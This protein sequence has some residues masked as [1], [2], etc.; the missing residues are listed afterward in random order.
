MFFISCISF[1]YA[2]NQKSE[3]QSAI[4]SE[5]KFRDTVYG[6]AID[7]LNNDLGLITPVDEPIY[8]LKHFTYTGTNEIWITK[9]WTS[10]PHYIC[11]YPKEKLIPNKIYSLKICLSHKSRSGMVN[12]QLGFYLS[13][14]HMIQLHLKGHY[15]SKN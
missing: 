15:K 8:F 12:K 4:E 2:Q 10:D 5:F 3:T 11:D 1:C 9:T 14:G 7:S 6:I 13:D